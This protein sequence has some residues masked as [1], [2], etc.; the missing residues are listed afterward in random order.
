MISNNFDPSIKRFSIL[1]TGLGAIPFIS[2]PLLMLTY[3]DYKIILIFLSIYS[4]LIINFICGANWVIVLF[5]SKKNYEKSL[6]F[7]LLFFII[8]IVP[9]ILVWLIISFQIYSENFGEEIFYENYML[10]LFGV[11]FIIILIFDIILYKSNFTQFWWFGM[12][13]FG[14]LVA[15]IFLILGNYLFLFG[16]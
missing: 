14:S 7:Y 5:N 2:F 4:G 12:R 15:G 11:L 8:P 6:Y 1:I 3:I 9:I 10:A 16:F 13:I